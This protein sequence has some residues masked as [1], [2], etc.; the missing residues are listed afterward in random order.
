M[1]VSLFVGYSTQLRGWGEQAEIFSPR[2]SPENS[3]FLLVMGRTSLNSRN[4]FT[5][6]S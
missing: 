4:C 2:E 1:L 3:E 5:A 6:A